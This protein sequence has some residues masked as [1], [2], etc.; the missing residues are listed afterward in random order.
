MAELEAITESCNLQKNVNM[1]I[2]KDLKKIKDL[3]YAIDRDHDA[4]RR[5]SRTG[6]SRKYLKSYDKT[7]DEPARD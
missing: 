7:E 5:R 1:T 2:K 3:V 4:G 6:I